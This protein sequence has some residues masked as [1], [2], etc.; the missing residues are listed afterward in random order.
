[1]SLMRATDL[2][3]R[4]GN[5]SILK[6]IDFEIR[7][8]ELIGLIGPNGAGKSTL[9]RLLTQ[10]EPAS[11]GEIQ[12][13]GKAIETLAAEERAR[14]IGYLVQ[15]GKAHWSESCKL[16]LIVIVTTLEDGD[17]S[18]VVENLRDITCG[19]SKGDGYITIGHAL[20][21]RGDHPTVAHLQAL[22]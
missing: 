14:R 2:E 3:Y 12:F 5:L 15:G 1:M 22:E 17:Y 4:I 20:Q 8:S 10:V 19:G 16:S 9:L 21:M 18:W 7:A 13:D 6:G 11:S